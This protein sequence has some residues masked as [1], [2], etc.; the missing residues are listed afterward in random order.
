MASTDHRADVTGPV[1]GGR[2]G[3]PF[4]LPPV[5]LDHHGYIAEE[6][7]LEGE[8]HSYRRVG[9]RGI[10]G[11]WDAVP[12]GT[13]P[14]CTRMLVVRPTDATACNGVVHVNWQNVTAGVELGDAGEADSLDG[15]IWVGVSAQAV[16]IDGYPGMEANALRGWDPD[17]YGPLNHPG[18]DYS[19]DIFTE[20]ARS[21]DERTLGGIRPRTLVASGGSQ[22]A[23]RLRTYANAI[24]PLT[25]VFDAYWLMVDGGFAPALSPEDDPDEVL[26]GMGGLR[27]ARIRDDLAVPVFVFNSESEAMWMTP[28]RQ[29]DSDTFRLWEVAGTSHT[30]GTPNTERMQRVF[31]RDGISLFAEGAL[32]STDSDVNPLS[33]DPALRA[34]TMHFHRWLA[35]GASPPTMPPIEIDESGDIRRDEHGNARGGVRLP[36]IEA[37]TAEHR[38][39]REGDPLA[40]LVGW[41]RPFTTDEL[42][43]LY[44]DGDGYLARWNAA[45]ERG[46]DGTFVLAEDAPALRE[47]A[48]QRA[49]A[50]FDADGPTP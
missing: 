32:D 10:D 20:A 42:R 36:D 33:Y 46:V 35:D 27:S 48:A 16:G 30:G 22:S 41:T 21:L 25:Q 12:T 28:A 29:P 2:R 37:P 18:D 11:R 6:F 44:G 23:M 3:R 4:S 38:G 24:H 47:A 43:A 34:A 9:E 15:R 40:A 26:D 17:R 50:L 19:F 45:L 39:L 7:F 5:D 14:F 8:A 1:T 49:V 13:A 31:E